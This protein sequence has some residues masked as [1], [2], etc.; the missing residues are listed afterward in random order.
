MRLILSLFAWALL[1]TPT[2]ASQPSDRIESQR[3]P[4]KIPP[5]VIQEP[6]DSPYDWTTNPESV[7]RYNALLQQVEQAAR[8]YATLHG[9]RFPKQ[10]DSEFMS[11]FPG[12]V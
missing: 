4:A 1:S 8:D 6:P 2:F 10:L 7:V 3:S 11:Y 5:G 12:G 9:N